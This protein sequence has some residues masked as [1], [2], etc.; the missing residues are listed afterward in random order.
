[1]RKLFCILLA[2]LAVLSACMTASAATV[3]LY[4]DLA[5]Q[6]TGKK[7][8]SVVS[9][10]SV[11]AE[12]I[13]PSSISDWQIVAVAPHAFMKNTTM[14]ALTMQEPMTEIGEYAFL[15][16]TAL[17]T[18]TLPSSLNVLGKAAFSGTTALS[19]VNLDETSV[20]AIEEYTF[21]NSALER[22][23]LPIVCNSI[24]DHAFENCRSLQYIAIPSS[25]KEIGENAFGGCDVLTIICK[26]GSYAAAFAEEYG[27]P[28]RFIDSWG[29]YLRGD[30]DGDDAV[31]IMDATKIQR[32]IAEL[33]ND[34]SQMISVRG[35]VDGNGL[36]ILDATAIQR[37]LA[38]IA[39]PYHINSIVKIWSVFD[40]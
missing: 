16:C 14:T 25:I 32:L 40:D 29:A 21:M 5:V 3:Y 36:N 30:A 11:D 33:I 9:M 15:D 34:D 39:N 37:C 18:V 26:E 13:I 4:D 35:D 27:Y 1:M 22:I 24:A 6:T 12:V 8:F 28:Y 2:L 23:E 19:S 10:S 17:R 38:D 20:A 31:T 7:E